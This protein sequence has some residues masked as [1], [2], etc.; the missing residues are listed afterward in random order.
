MDV[1]PSK[2]TFKFDYGGQE[3][4]LKKIAVAKFKKDKGNLVESVEAIIKHDAEKKLYYLIIRLAT[5]KNIIFTGI[6]L[7]KKS[8]VKKNDENLDVLAFTL[9]EK[10]VLEAHRIK[11][12]I[13]GLDNELGEFYRE[14]EKIVEE[15]SDAE[16][17]KEREA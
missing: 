15:K 12:Q 14:L 5:T 9:N 13:K 11:M 10:K 16:K 7:P 2:S 6:L 8:A 4:I 1:D 3:D 17:Q